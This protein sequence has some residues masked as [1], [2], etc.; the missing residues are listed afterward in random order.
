M[1]KIVYSLLII[2]G[3]HNIYGQSWVQVPIDLNAYSHC[4]YTDTTDNL[5]YFG[6]MFGMN[7]SDT[8]RGVAVWDNNTVSGCAEGLMNFMGGDQSGVPVSEIMRFQDKIYVGGGATLFT[9]GDSIW[10]RGIGV[11]DGVIWDSINVGLLDDYGQPDGV[12][13]MKVIGNYLYVGGSFTNINGAEANG[14]AKFDGSNW[15]AVHA[16]PQWGGTSLNLVRDIAEYNGEIYVAGVLTDGYPYD[17][18][19]NICRFNGSEWEQLG[20]GIGGGFSTVFGMEVYNGK[21]FVC[22]SFN[23]LDRPGNPGNRIAVWNGSYWEQV[24]DI[25]GSSESSYAVV[26]DMAVLNGELYVVG[27]FEN[28]NGNPA[29]NF[30]KFDGVNWCSYPDVFDAFI[31]QVE[32]YDNEI[33]ITGFFTEISG[34]P[35]SLYAKFDPNSIPTECHSV[36]SLKE[37]DS[38]NFE[39]YPNPTDGAINISHNASVEPTRIELLNLNGQILFEITFSKQVLFNQEPGM[40]LIR[41]FHENEQLGIRRIILK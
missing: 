40:Y 17:T 14:L 6:G 1:R 34:A 16:F 24:V 10:T 4:L 39:I 15:S 27:E 7:G 23:K 20:E 9:V 33:Y 2:L 32:A 8:V 22:G 31:D 26:K 29:N 25:Y 18:M 28:V 19:Y 12:G 35:I 13:E 11:W 38:D 37:F 5:L 3:C 36:L 21:L 41:L 30:A